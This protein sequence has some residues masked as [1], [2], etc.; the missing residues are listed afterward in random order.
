MASRDCIKTIT[1]GSTV[2]EMQNSVV[3]AGNTIVSLSLDGTLNY[4]DAE[5]LEVVK[6]VAGHRD[7]AAAI[8]WDASTS[9]IASVCQGG[10]MVKWAAGETPTSFVASLVKGE[11]HTKRAVGVAAASGRIASIG[12]DDHV[13]VAD[14]ATGEFIFK[15]CRSTARAYVG[16][17]KLI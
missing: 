5:S 2:N 4:I 16:G 12:W 6:H 10:R 11:A 13:R 9:G 1:I 14:A 7:A 17:R 15:V 8:A 3:W